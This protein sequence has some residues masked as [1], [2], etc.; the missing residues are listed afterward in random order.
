LF[1]N[2][3]AA[4][5]LAS[6]PKSRDPVNR[7]MHRDETAAGPGVNLPP[8][9]FDWRL[10]TLRQLSAL[11]LMAAS[12]FTLAIGFAHHPAWRSDAETAAAYVRVYGGNAAAEINANVLRPGA[13]FVQGESAAL[14]ETAR[15]AFAPLRILFRS[16]SLWPRR[17][18]SLSSRRRTLHRSPRHTSRTSCTSRRPC[19]RR[20]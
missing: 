16:R 3:S 18:R 2:E 19:A 8:N 13:A 14:Y 17:R 6:E 7:S 10:M 12:G 9:E 20:S 1:L 15:N 4:A 11:Y 5:R